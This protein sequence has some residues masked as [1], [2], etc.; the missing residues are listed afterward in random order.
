[1]TSKFR[2]MTLKSILTRNDADI[3][4]VQWV[5]AVY[6]VAEMSMWTAAH[7]AALQRYAQRLISFDNQWDCLYPSHTRFEGT[8]LDCMLYY[9]GYW[10]GRMRDLKR[11]FVET[12]EYSPRAWGHLKLPLANMQCCLTSVKVLH[13][14]SRYVLHLD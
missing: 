2:R 11:R 12:G 8:L 10:S 14:G 13:E 9:V 5:Q 7:R 6:R 3:L 1:M 4:P